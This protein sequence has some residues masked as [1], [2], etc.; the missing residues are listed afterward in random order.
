MRRWF[1][2]RFAN[3]DLLFDDPIKFMEGVLISYCTG[4]VFLPLNVKLLITWG[5]SNRNTKSF[6][7]QYVI[8]DDNYQVFLALKRFCSEYILVQIQK[9]FLF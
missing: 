1:E 7:L 3:R 9:T 5:G 2:N 8:G 6:I 4:S